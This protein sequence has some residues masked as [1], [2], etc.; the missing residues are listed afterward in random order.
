LEDLE[1]KLNDIEGAL[2]QELSEEVKEGLEEIR[3]E[4]EAEQKELAEELDKLLDEVREANE[5]VNEL[6]EQNESDA[7]SVAHLDSVGID[8]KPMWDTITNRK[9]E[10]ALLLNNYGGLVRRAES[11]RG[12]ISSA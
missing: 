9:N 8:V 2:S 7:N 6:N 5:E 11:L 1:G 4:K 3:E 12:R 10:L